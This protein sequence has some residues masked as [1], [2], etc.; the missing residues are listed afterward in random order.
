M[1]R[2]NNPEMAEF[3]L[4]K[5]SL[6]NSAESNAETYSFMLDTIEKLMTTNN[7]SSRKIG[8][9]GYK[10]DMAALLAFF[11]KLYHFNK[12]NLYSVGENIEFDPD[13]MPVNM[14]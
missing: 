4:T 12:S 11:F 13:L 3:I 2:K 7:V 10:E 8:I 1:G 9:S 14:R 6:A 5:G